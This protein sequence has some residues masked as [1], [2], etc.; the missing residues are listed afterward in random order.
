VVIA[1]AIAFDLPDTRKAGAV[2]A[3]FADAKEHAGPAIP[4]ELAGA[5]LLIA[6]G[7]VGLRRRDEAEPG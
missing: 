5:V 7:L 4:L 6:G 1:I 2:G 3:D